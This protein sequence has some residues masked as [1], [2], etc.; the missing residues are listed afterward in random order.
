MERSRNAIEREYMRKIVITGEI[1][2]NRWKKLKGL[3]KLKK[4]SKFITKRE[5]GKS[6]KSRKSF[7]IKGAGIKN[8]ILVKLSFFF[9]FNPSA[10]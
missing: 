6:K 5:R 7:W 3:G 2:E 9:V 8:G 4:I 1:W 10:L